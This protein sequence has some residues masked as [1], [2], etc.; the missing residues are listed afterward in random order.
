MLWSA[1]SSFAITRLIVLVSVLRLF[2]L[3]AQLPANTNNNFA[4]GGAEFGH[5]ESVEVVPNETVEENDDSNSGI[6]YCETP[7]EFATFIRITKVRKEGSP[8]IIRRMESLTSCAD[9]CRANLDRVENRL[10]DCHGFSVTKTFVENVCEFFDEIADE[11]R[12]VNTGDSHSTYYEKQ[13][14]AIPDHCAD[15][16]YSFELQRDKGLSTK[17][18]ESIVVDDRKRCLNFCLSNP[19]CHSVNFNRHN[20]SCQV[21]DKT[22][23]NVNGGLVDMSGV[24]YYENTCSR[25]LNRCLPGQKVDFFVTKNANVASM[26]ASLGSMSL[27]NC[28]R[29]CIDSTFVFCRSVKYDSGTGECV[30]LEDPSEG[31]LFS[32]G[33]DLYEPVCF[34]ADVDVLCAGDFA[35]ERIPNSNIVAEGFITSSKGP[36]VEH[37]IDDCLVDERCVAFVYDKVLRSCKLYASNRK[38]KGASAV[39]DNS[40]DFYELACDR[41]S[42]RVNIEGPPPPPPPEDTTTVPT[43]HRRST[44]S[45]EEALALVSDISCGAELI[46]HGKTFR[47]E[48]RNLHHVNV[49]SFEQCRELC[50]RASDICSSFAYNA[51]SKDCLLSSTDI[52]NKVMHDVA[53]QAN[54]DFDLY[55]FHGYD[56]NANPECSTPMTT[57][58]WWESWSHSTPSE[59]PTFATLVN[60]AAA[61]TIA[62]TTAVPQTT[63]FQIPST[64]ASSKAPTPSPVPLSA[65]APSFTFN[66]NAFDI[67]KPSMSAEIDASVDGVNNEAEDLAIFQAG[68]IFE[69]PTSRASP[70]PVPVYSSS[71]TTMEVTTSP[72]EVFSKDEGPKKFFDPHGPVL[73]EVVTDDS[74]PLF[75]GDKNDSEDGQKGFVDIEPDEIPHVAEGTHFRR[76]AQNDVEVSAICLEHGVNVTFM[77]KNAR[78]TGAVYAAERFS[79]CKIVVEKRDEFSIFVNRPTS[80]NW[81]NALEVGNEM[82]VVLVMSNDMVLPFDVTTKEDFFYQITCDY[83]DEPE[84]AIIHAG[85]VVG[86]PEPKSI[87]SALSPNNS[88]TKVALR[89]LKDHHSVTNVFM[90]E[91]LTALVETDAD[92]SRVRVTECNATRVGGREPVPN[93]VQLI[94]DGCTL[95]PQIISD[96][97]SESSGLQAT[98]TAFRIDGSD[99]IDIACNVVICRKACE[100]KDTCA[101]IVQR[102]R[103][104]I[105]KA[106]K[107]FAPNVTILGEDIVMVDQRLRVL[108][109]NENLTDNAANSSGIRAACL[110][111]SLLFVILLLFLL[112]LIALTV[113]ICTNRCTRSKKIFET[114]IP[115]QV[116][117]ISAL[118]RS[119]HLDI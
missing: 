53:T 39:P 108:V 24:D 1:S 71:Y 98:L 30:I 20:G 40:V 103:R 4:F 119:D 54:L 19:N 86:G 116:E 59:Q 68:D 42:I 96:M 9:S 27:R 88:P 73:S 61:Q 77:T 23:R 72:L 106:S 92:V 69:E 37:C 118:P 95:M 84:K 74:K 10:F 17:P 12:V 67:T 45:S 49:R 83:R 99:Q 107:R 79:Q 41:A 33:T 89:I 47:I 115:N 80:N 111:P 57:R 65:L 62:F 46:E 105:A 100:Q 43:Q 14:L 48:Y 101:A 81:C 22:C 26:E 7:H 28:M 112:S 85:I 2:V 117:A 91:K 75:L 13:C 8:A 50:G 66:S 31:S 34:N 113:S 6:G 15:T 35:F 97:R 21:L 76:L 32:P 102:H 58:S 36:K 64:I 18:L 44:T 87:K 82:T 104:M 114:E 16:A 60:E 94:A 70:S 55:S 51:R 11:M 52:K 29:E 38:T 93:S 25:D 5:Q 56:I 109:E 110:D 3:S 90:G 63:P 78:Y